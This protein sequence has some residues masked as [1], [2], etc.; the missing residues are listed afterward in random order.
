VHTSQEQCETLTHLFE[1]IVVRINFPII[2][3][4]ATKTITFLLGYK[5]EQFKSR[6]KALQTEMSTANT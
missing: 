4:T 1:S 5:Q 3:H 2:L 6:M